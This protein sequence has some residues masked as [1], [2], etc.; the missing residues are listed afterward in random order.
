MYG[1][2]EL[3]S[4]ST[5]NTMQY[6]RRFHLWSL[7][8]TLVNFKRSLFGGMEEY[9]NRCR[10]LYN[11]IDNYT[12]AVGDMGC[13]L[14][15]RLLT[16]ATE[17]QSSMSPSG[18][19]ASLAPSTLRL[20]LKFSVPYARNN[21]FTGRQSILKLIRHMFLN[22]ERTLSG[23]VALYGLPGVGKTQ[24]ALEYLHLYRS[25]YSKIYWLNASQRSYLI[26][27]LAALQSPTGLTPFEEERP[28]EERAEQVLSWLGLEEGWLV[29][30]DNVDDFKD[31]HRLL[32]KIG[33]AHGDILDSLRRAG[34]LNDDRTRGC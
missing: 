14:G 6:T 29:I 30:L 27:E 20:P 8:L 2:C 32:Q 34:S 4:H 10:R 21:F 15:L 7:L 3:L 22:R 11:A 18:H 9:E 23:R 17:I 5:E 33:S 26:S 12:S 19:A 24:I 25:A 16:I 28:M 13:R 1:V 31:I